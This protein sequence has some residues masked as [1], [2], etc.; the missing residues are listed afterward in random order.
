MAKLTI[1]RFAIAVVFA[2]AAILP[3]PPKA[4][5]LVPYPRALWASLLRRGVGDPFEILETSYLPLSV[6]RSAA[7]DDGA[8]LFLA[9]ADWR[10]TPAEHRIS[11]DVP[12]ME[13]DGVKVEVEDGGVIAVTGERKTEAAVAEDD[14]W[15]RVERSVGKFWRRF[16]MPANADVERVTARL[17]DG[18]LRITVPKLDEAEKTKTEAKGP[19]L[20]AIVSDEK[21]TEDAQP[22]RAE[23]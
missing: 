17:K 4:A 3:P 19:K 6:P 22:A 10:E 23:M 18:V 12:G 2:A 5:A 14:R 16:R 15:H 21:K 9:R 13:N 8:A 11:I 1:F 7:G 20:I